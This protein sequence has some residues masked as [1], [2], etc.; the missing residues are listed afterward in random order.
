M[1]YGLV[2]RL[3]LRLLLGTVRMDPRCRGM[4]DE[5]QTLW[6][7]SWCLLQ[8]DEVSLILD[9][10]VAYYPLT[11]YSNFIVGQVTPDMLEKLT[12][13]TYSKSFC[14][15]LHFAASLSDCTKR[16]QTG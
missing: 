16:S 11:S 8:L 12:Y 2:L 4:A 14:S 7:C 10:I 1:C 6:Y 3:Q 9:N 13:G 15:L 5:Q